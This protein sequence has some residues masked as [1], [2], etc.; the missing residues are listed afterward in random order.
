MAF[1]VKKGAAATKK[2]T[3]TTKKG[4]KKCPTCGGKGVC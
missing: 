3:G 2:G 4:G 1:P